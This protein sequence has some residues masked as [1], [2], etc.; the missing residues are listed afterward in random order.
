ME[1]K[2]WRR[3][4][5]ASILISAASLAIIFMLTS[6]QRAIPLI[7]HTSPLFLL[8]I[9]IIHTLHWFFWA[10]RIKIMAHALGDKISFTW[11]F[12][13]VMVN[14]F[15][16]SI[17][18]SSFGGEP[19]RIY[20]LSQRNLSGGD[21]TAL[22]L[23]ERLIDFIFFGVA[24]P[25]M[26]IL[27][28]IT[29]NLK[30]L[31]YELLAA[32]LIFIFGGFFLLFIV[33]HASWFKKRIRKF[34]RVVRLL[35]KNEERRKNVMKKIEREFDSFVKGMVVI[36][37]RKW[38]YFLG[39]LGAT[40]VMWVADFSIPSLI[41][42]ALGHQPFWLLSITFQM[43]ILLITIVPISPGGSGLAEFS[44][45]FLYSQKLPKD[46]VGAVVILWRILTFYMNLFV[47]LA[48]T[49][50]YIKKGK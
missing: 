47:G 29:I 26:F 23:G 35:V 34:E 22:T 5:I 46:L 4:L 2:K 27:L 21:A 7:I 9:L 19:S 8:I 16:A 28:G 32:A 25:I 20:M 10:L 1:L 18:P 45:Y 6:T 13:I 38:L 40:V 12:R 49:L 39:A 31:Q 15:M 42:L 17:T 44:A 11:A 50:H 30:D 3:W 14:L 24:L 36:F 48:F 43:I 37:K 41:L 33:T